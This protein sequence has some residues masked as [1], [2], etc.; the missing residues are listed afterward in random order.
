[1]KY[2][3][4]SDHYVTSVFFFL[5]EVKYR[6]ASVHYVTSVFFFS[7]EVKY[8]TASVHYVTSG[9]PSILTASLFSGIYLRPHTYISSLRPLCSLVST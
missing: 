7:Q 6:T 9:F 2:R 3:T 8:R 5:Q 4:A 1:M